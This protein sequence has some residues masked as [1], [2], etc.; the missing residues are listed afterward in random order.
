MVAKAKSKKKDN[1]KKNNNNQKNKIDKNKWKRKCY[2]CHKERHYIKDYYEKKK[3]R[4]LQKESNGKTIV[5]LEDESDLDAANIL[6]VIEKQRID[7]WILNSGCSFH[8]YPNKD[9]FKT[10]DCISG[11]I[12]LE[13]NLTCKVARIKTINN[14]MFD[15][16]VKDLNQVR[17]VLDHKRI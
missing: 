2:V 10:F 7:K 9:F 4:K 12:L 14:K 5:A 6:V 11:K 1:R 3:L 13:N 16:V 17:Y 15:G 8:M